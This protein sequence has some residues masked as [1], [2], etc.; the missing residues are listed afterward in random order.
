MAHTALEIVKTYA[1]S[2]AT[3]FG[4]PN[5]QHRDEPVDSQN[6]GVIYLNPA[7]RSG[8][9]LVLL[10]LLP[11]PVPKVD[12][13]SEVWGRCLHFA[14]DLTRER[15]ASSPQ[16]FS[17]FLKSRKDLLLVRKMFQVCQL[18]S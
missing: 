18:A 14:M 11:P 3:L 10:P 12:L 2:F 15:A 13:P 6:T 7:R 9:R 8:A 5:T 1:A 4:T 17:K 16:T